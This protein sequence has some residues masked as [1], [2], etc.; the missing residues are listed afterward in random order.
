MWTYI[1]RE[2]AE[3]LWAETLETMTE[4]EKTLAYAPQPVLSDADWEACWNSIRGEVEPEPVE[5]T[6]PELIDCPTCE[7]YGEVERGYGD[8]C[9]DEDC[10]DCDGTGKIEKEED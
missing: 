5:E 4:E 2:L 10:P 9:Y 8:E 3:Q 7:G 6:E 1:D